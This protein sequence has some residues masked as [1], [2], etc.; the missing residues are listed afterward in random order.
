VGI[1]FRQFSEVSINDTV[2]ESGPL[3][4]GALLW[5]LFMHD[6]N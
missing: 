4:R 2:E 6:R 5:V 3:H 1:F